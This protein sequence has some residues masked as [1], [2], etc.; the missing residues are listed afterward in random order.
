M[1]V[2]QAQC[3]AHNHDTATGDADG[4]GPPPL[5]LASKEGAR[6][7]EAEAARFN[8][9]DDDEAR[10]LLLH[11]LEA[12][13]WARLVLDGRPYPSPA[14]L[15]RTA[16]AAAAA[17]DDAALSTALAAHPRI[18]ERP[19]GPGTSASFSRAEQS[20]V[21]PDD[22]DVATR[23][24][25]GN[26][27]YEEKFGHVFLIRAAGRTSEEILAGLQERLGNDPGTERE[28]VKQQLGQIAVL[29]LRQQLAALA[30]APSPGITDDPGAAR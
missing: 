25:E 30:T 23:L 9:L 13:P 2:T 11:C 19:A 16:E 20:G 14:D 28:V 7:T 15:E 5:G 22:Q 12:A 27:A 18:G 21:D 26:L 3:L 10:T 29:R 24:R 17:M 1:A 4:A 6:M 8:A